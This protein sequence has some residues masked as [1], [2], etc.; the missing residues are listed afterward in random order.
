MSELKP[1][2]AE[3]L[4]AAQSQD[5]EAESRMRRRGQR[6]FSHH[7][8]ADFLDACRRA[9]V[10]AHRSQRLDRVLGPITED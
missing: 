9:T 7:T 8:T 2:W 4:G 5:T 6:P 3:A 1:G 10:K